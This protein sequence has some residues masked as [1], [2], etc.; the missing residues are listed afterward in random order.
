MHIMK[1][2]S[3]YPNMF[4]IIWKAM[5]VGKPNNVLYHQLRGSITRKL[6]TRSSEVTFFYST[7]TWNSIV[8]LEIYIF[9]YPNEINF[10]IEIHVVLLENETMDWRF[11]KSSITIV[12]FPHFPT[13]VLSL[14]R[15]RCSLQKNCKLKKLKCDL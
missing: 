3:L 15:K 9:I 14:A 4:C 8:N 5:N 7:E 12:S 6:W 1:I 11:S 13:W 10:L 2:N